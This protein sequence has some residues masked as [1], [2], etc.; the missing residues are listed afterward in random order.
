M[1]QFQ[2]SII[3]MIFFSLAAG[4]ASAPPK[5]PQQLVKQ[6]EARQKKDEINQSIMSKG[7]QIA[8]KGSRDYQIGPE[9]LLEVNIYGQEDMERI[10]RVNGDGAISLPLIGVVKVAGDTPQKL[11]KRLQE[12]YGSRYL[13]NPQISVFVKE[14]RHQRVA[15]T[16]ALKNPGFYEMIGPRSLLEMLAM[17]GGLDEKGGDYVHVIRLK[18]D[19]PDA[20]APKLEDTA[21]SFAPNSE[22]LVIDVRRLAKEPKLN[23][24]V[25]QGDV[26]HVPFAG[27]AYVLGSVNKPGSVP[28]K[29][30]LTVSQAV[31]MAGSPVSALAAPGN[32]SILRLDENGQ[33]Q[34]I[35]VN[36]KGVMAQKEPD[37]ILK[38]GD[39][40]YVP[41]SVVR[42]FLTDIRT[43]VGAGMS[44]GY[45]V[46]I[47]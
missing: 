24:Q 39:V 42:K 20:K 5:A 29:N 37:V 3:I 44:V 16:G 12:L 19:K 30:N 31:A 41:E 27:F 1:R 38:E 40:V 14:Y 11:E 47:P 6:F 46:A 15:L 2:Q 45:T 28:V 43:L 13:R 35:P 36:L 9:D 8:V 33:S 4:C 32:I 7:A 34:K 22:T 18:G 25:Q 21:Q 17:A 10:I 23:V 26:I